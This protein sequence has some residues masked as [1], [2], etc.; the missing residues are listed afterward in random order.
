MD[1]TPVSSSNISAIGYDAESMTLEVQFNS[2]SAYQYQGVPA[3]VHRE[4][5]AA[6]SVGR[7]FIAHV[8][9]HYPASRVG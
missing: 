5:M 7:Y 4:L 1:I 2:G 8:R 3:S 6:G 9:N